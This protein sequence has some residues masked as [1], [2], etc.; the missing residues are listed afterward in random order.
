MR[1]INPIHGMT[2]L[3]LIGLILVVLFFQSQIPLWR[4]LLF[5]YTLWIGCPFRFEGD[6]GPET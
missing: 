1:R 4:D 6:L 3:L 5:R 2:L